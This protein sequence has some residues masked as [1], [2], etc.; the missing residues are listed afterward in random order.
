MGTF[1]RVHPSLLTYRLIPNALPAPQL[2]LFPA[3]YQACGSSP[4]IHVHRLWLHYDCHV[5]LRGVHTEAAPWTNSH[6]FH[7]RAMR[8]AT[9]CTSLL[10]SQG[11]LVGALHMHTG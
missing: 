3:P 9:C 11:R 1:R 6:D 7:A 4:T 10:R 2:A 5:G 8:R